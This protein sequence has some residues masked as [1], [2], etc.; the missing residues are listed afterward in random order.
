ME[1]SSP[2]CVKSW[3]M[4][5]RNATNIC[6]VNISIITISTLHW[7]TLGWCPSYLTKGAHRIARWSSI[8]PGCLGITTAQCTQRSTRTNPNALKDYDSAI[9]IWGKDPL[10]LRASYAKA[11]GYYTGLSNVRRT[12]ELDSKEPQRRSTHV[13]RQQMH[14]AYSRSRDSELPLLFHKVLSTG[15]TPQIVAMLSLL[16]LYN[17]L[18]QQMVLPAPAAHI[19]QE[20]QAQDTSVFLL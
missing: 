4:L 5:N 19:G 11:L 13:A 9:C 17:P 1:V 14:K 18:Q 3:C 15:V 2:E 6:C 8:P 20:A 16:W 7:L 12:M 10:C